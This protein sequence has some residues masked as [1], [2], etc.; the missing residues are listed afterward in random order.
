MSTTSAMD[1]IEKMGSY[2]REDL[3]FGSIYNGTHSHIPTIVIIPMIGEA[4]VIIPIAS[5]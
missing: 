1:I 4:T 5:Q 2:V 3:A